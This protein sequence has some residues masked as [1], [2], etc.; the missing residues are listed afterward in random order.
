MVLGLF[1]AVASPAR[2]DSPEKHFAGQIKLSDKR[3]PQQAKSPGAYI[4]SINKLAKTNFQADKATKSWTIYF[5]AFLKA[6]T[7]DVEV[8]IKLYDVSSKERALLASFEQFIDTRGQKTIISK[9]NLEQKLVGVN[10]EIQM[11]IE[12]KGKQLAAGRFKIL[13]EG[14]HFSGKVDFSDDEAKKKD[15]E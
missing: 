11:V 6:P 3:F 4:A 9:L 14:E 1:A 2:A 13:G 10:K 15:E 7:D 5:A 8:Q 12:S